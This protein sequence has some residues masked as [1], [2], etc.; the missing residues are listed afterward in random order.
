[1]MTK[2]ALKS[3]AVWGAIITLVSALGVVPFVSGFDPSTGELTLNIYQIGDLLGVAGVGIGGALSL[4]G[5]LK[6]RTFIKGLW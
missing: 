6:A 1:M 2:G 5:R 3:R 4:F